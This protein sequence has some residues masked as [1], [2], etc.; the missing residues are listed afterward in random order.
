MDGSFL[1]QV[2][3]LRDL[4]STKELGK[5]VLLI[6]ATSNSP[7]VYL[8]SEDGKIIIKGEC[9]P[10]DVDEFFQQ[11]LGF[12]ESKFKN[13]KDME[14][15]FLFTYFNSSSGK[16]ILDIVKILA[17]LS[18]SGINVE[19]YWYYE[20]ND[21]DMLSVGEEISRLA[22]IPLKLIEAEDLA[23]IFHSEI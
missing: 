14:G 8:N 7:F 23:I 5:N 17:G 1:D 22:K 11:I 10:P 6:E 13:A 12:I 2:N 19:C 4:I 15:H 18:R 21:G 3:H 20:K 9:R 16:F